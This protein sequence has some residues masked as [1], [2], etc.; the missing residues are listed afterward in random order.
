MSKLLNNSTKSM[1]VARKWIEVNDLPGS[2]YPSK[3]I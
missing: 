2:Q 3:R 1:S